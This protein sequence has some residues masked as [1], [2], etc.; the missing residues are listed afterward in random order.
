[1]IA[2]QTVGRRNMPRCAVLLV[3]YAA[4][5]EMCHAWSS[6]IAAQRRTPAVLPHAATELRSEDGAAPHKI[7]SCLTPTAT[8]RAATG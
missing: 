1:M 5:L 4:A 6:P 8:V 7:S 3:L 2:E